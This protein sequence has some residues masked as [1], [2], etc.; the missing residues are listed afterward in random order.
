MISHGYFPASYTASR[1]RFRENLALVRRLWPSVRLERQTLDPDADLTTDWI[2]A[3]AGDTRQHLLMLTTGEHG[4][5]G[6]VGSAILQLFLSECMHL[7][8]P[9]TTSLLLV[10]AINPWG[11]QNWRRV[12]PENVDLNRNFML[13]TAGFDPGFNPAYRKLHGL[14]NPTGPANILAIDT[15]AFAAGLTTSFI[16]HGVHNFKNAVLMGQYHTA[17]GIYYGGCQLQPETRMMMRLY[18]Q[19]TRGYE[20]IVHVDMHTGFGPRYQMS[21]VNSALEK[22]D[23][24]AFRQ[25]FDYPLVV[26]GN[27]TEFYQIQGDMVDWVYHLISHTAPAARLYA[28]AFEFGT[29]GNSLRA[30][31]RSLR[32]MILENRLHQHGAAS[33]AG[34]SRIRS[35][36]RELFYPTEA[37]WRE[38]A[39]ADARQALRGILRSEGLIER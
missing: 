17:N 34:G 32:A 20:H 3:Q 9:H 33:G 6:F 25:S 14:L 35:E 39:L 27:A 7:L 5:E 4:V 38:K 23:S 29:F 24:A 8:D 16:R 30:T 15:V 22:R 26:K 36:F 11:M 19:A 1:A 28:T 12:N 21:L 13:D 10:H 18:E 37:R 2:T 31:L